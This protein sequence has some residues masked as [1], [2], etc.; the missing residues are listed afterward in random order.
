M[1][2]LLTRMMVFCGQWKYTMKISGRRTFSTESPC[3]A[4]GV[5]RHLE[6]LMASSSSPVE[7]VPG[8]RC[9]PVPLCMTFSLKLGRSAHPCLSLHVCMRKSVHAS[10]HVWVHV[11][12][13]VCACVCMHVCACMCVHACVCMH[14]CVQV[15]ACEWACVGACVCMCVCMCVHVMCVCM[16]VCVHACVCPSHTNTDT[17]TQD[18]HATPATSH[19]QPHPK[20]GHDVLGRGKTFSGVSTGKTTPTPARARRREE[21]Q[22][23]SIYLYAFVV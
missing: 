9:L 11:C 14:V 16:H 1:A 20:R 5:R 6:S 17:H 13:C 12:A 4:R 22:R 7:E 15:C 10:V 2:D 3:Q 18:I 23:G 8:S 21:Q 19:P